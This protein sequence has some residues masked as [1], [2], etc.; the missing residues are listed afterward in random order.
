MFID[1]GEVSGFLIWTK[2]LPPR[3]PLLP[4]HPTMCMRIYI[5]VEC[6]VFTHYVESTILFQIYFLQVSAFQHNHANDF[7]LSQMFFL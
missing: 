4:H 1:P 2:T 3:C 6:N 5:Y 7:L